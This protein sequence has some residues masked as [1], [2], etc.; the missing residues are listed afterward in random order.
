MKI[1]DG[2]EVKKGAVMEKKEA[3]EHIG[4]LRKLQEKVFA[5][6]I[7]FVIIVGIRPFILVLVLYMMALLLLAFYAKFVGPVFL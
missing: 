1:K 4:T 2:V 5:I 6:L 7:F 3:K